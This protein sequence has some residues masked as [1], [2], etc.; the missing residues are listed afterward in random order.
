MSTLA[1][2][3]ARMGSTRCPGKVMRP[4]NGVPMIE[5]LLRRLAGARRVDRI[6]LA[7]SDDPANQPLAAHVRSLGFDVFEGREDD[8]LD[9]FHRAA[10]PYGP[11]V[12]VRITGDCPL[13][14]AGL[15][16]AVLGAY[17]SGSVDYAS[18]ANP[19]TYPDGLDVEAFSFE[20]LAAA[21]ADATR[22]FD[23]EHVTPFLRDSGRFKTLNVGA[24]ED[25]SAERWTVDEPEDFEV[26]ASV[27]AHFGPRVDFGWREVL[28]LSRARP[29]LFE[30]NR[31][32]ARNEGAVLTPGQ[33]LQRRASRL[34][35]E[36]Q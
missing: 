19:P 35:G 30:R 33:K 15:V 16:D 27:F 20:A 14:D 36:R 2:V 11:T 10:L 7:T 8:V 31:G 1:V 34:A 18:N 13:V 26:V 6:V 4:I 25:L 24:G 23:R 22:P 32:I 12:V 9:R 17:S 21:A 28:A 5:L 29:D 3:Q